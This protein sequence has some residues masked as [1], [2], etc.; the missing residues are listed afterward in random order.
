MRGF[1]IP[2]RGPVPLMTSEQACPIWERPPSAQD[3]TEVGRRCTSPRA[4]GRFEL[5]RDGAACLHRLSDRQKANLSYWIYRHNL[6]YRM[7]DDRTSGEQSGC[8]QP[9]VDQKQL[10]PHT[11]GIGAHADLPAGIDPL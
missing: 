6:D 5:K 3:V 8:R 7:F 11:L 2:P 9:G 1:A 4:G 10:G